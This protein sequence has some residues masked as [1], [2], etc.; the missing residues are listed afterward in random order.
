MWYPDFINFAVKNAITQADNGKWYLEPE[1]RLI[2]NGD[3][4]QSM[5]FEGESDPRTL[6]QIEDVLKLEVERRNISNDKT[7]YVINWLHEIITTAID[8][9]VIQEETDYIK[10]VV[11]FMKA[12][13]GIEDEQEKTDG[14]ETNE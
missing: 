3:N 9:A 12:N 6:D 5:Q 11:E 10:N 4:V 14:K 2:I 13:H 7:P 8:P 1:W